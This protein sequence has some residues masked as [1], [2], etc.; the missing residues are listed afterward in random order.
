MVLAKWAVAGF[1]P[2][3][4]LR[5]DGTNPRT[6][7]FSLEVSGKPIRLHDTLVVYLKKT[8]PVAVDSVL[9][10]FAGTA[11][12]VRGDSIVVTLLKTG[13]QTVS[14][15]VFWGEKRETVTQTVTVLADEKPARYTYTIV[16]RYPHDRRAYT[17]GLE[18]YR[19]TLYES[20][21]IKGQSTL[22]KLHYKTGEVLQKVSLDAAYFGEGI[23][24]LNGNL[25]LLTWQ[26]R[27]GFVYDPETLQLRSSFVYGNSEEGWGL[28]NDGVSLYKSDGTEKIWIL[29]AET[30]VEEGFIQM[31]TDKDVFS[32]AN[33]LEYARGKIYANS[34]QKEGI[35][36][37]NPENGVIE[38]IVDFRGLREKVTQ[39]S[40]LD[41]FNGI[42][43]N[44]RTDT[45]FVTGKNWDVLFEVR[46]VKK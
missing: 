32:K 39:H 20:T 18:F 30:L 45:F 24:L 43:Y 28:C 33:E 14:A 29:N 41:V 25:Y 27:K 13:K 10:T 22:R 36:V 21:G 9:F 46:I 4:L 6:R 5:C 34:Y 16:N 31:V 23:T 42:A 11:L 12:P 2:L 44:P 3:L 17:Q 38:G 19:D 35:M 37:I 40:E 8:K 7:Y 15:T 1:L 26:N